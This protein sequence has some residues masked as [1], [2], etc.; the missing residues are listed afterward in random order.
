MFCLVLIEVL[1][2][3][4]FHPGHEDLINYIEN[5]SFK[6]FKY[7]EGWVFFVRNV[8]KSLPK[9]FAVTRPNAIYFRVQ[10][11]PNASNIHTL[12]DLYA[13]V[14]SILAQSRFQSVR[15]RFTAELKELRS[16][17]PSPQTTQSIISLL[18][19][20]KFFR[21]KVRSGRNDVGWWFSKQVQNWLLENIEIKSHFY[22]ILC[23][24]SLMP[25]PRY[26]F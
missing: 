25:C 13:E 17:E 23:R 4:P 5:V 10:T 3:L 22:E 1:H 19:G 26:Y 16:K 14:I 2:Q 21:V 8:N 6:H 11:G 15:K 12:A 9:E 20:M 24:K 18:M 7:R